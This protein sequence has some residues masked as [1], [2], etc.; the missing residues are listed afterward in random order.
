MPPPSASPFTVG[1]ASGHTRPPAHFILCV[2]EPCLVLTLIAGVDSNEMNL[3]V[4]ILSL[5]QSLSLSTPCVW[6]F[7]RRPEVVSLTVR[8]REGW[9][10][11]GM[12]S[13]SCVRE[14]L[15]SVPWFPLPLVLWKHRSPLGV[16]GP[17]PAG[18]AHAARGHFW[19]G[20]LV[21]APLGPDGLPSVPRA[22][23]SAGPPFALE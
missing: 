20:S 12:Q 22:A 15:R 6:F 16:R 3:G 5:G 18:L 17:R 13:V 7:P 1:E 23:F 8:P 4:N 14:V 2:L 10:G 21:S 9:V 11:G 19:A